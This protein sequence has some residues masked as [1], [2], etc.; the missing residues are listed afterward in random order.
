MLFIVGDFPSFLGK[1]E[2]LLTLMPFDIKFIFAILSVI[3]LEN[4]NL[5][6]LES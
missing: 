5:R 1:V 6:Q 4:K 2:K 3:L